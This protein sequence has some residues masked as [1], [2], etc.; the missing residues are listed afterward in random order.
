[1][2]VGATI[3]LACGAGVHQLHSPPP[4]RAFISAQLGPGDGEEEDLRERKAIDSAALAL[5]ARTET[6]KTATRSEMAEYL[7]PWAQE[8][9]LDDDVNDEYEGVQVSQRAAYLH[10]RR[11]EGR[12]WDEDDY[13]SD[14]AGMAEFTPDELSEDYALPLETVVAYMLAI[15][16]DAK[17]LNLEKPVKGMC[18]PE[19]I[20]ELTA[21]LS[22]VDPIAAREELCESTLEELADGMPLT[23]DELLNLCRQNDISALIG[24]ETR[25]KVDDLD[26]LLDAAEREIAFLGDRPRLQE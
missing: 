6:Y 2:R 14:G 1:M 26:S 25:I 12:L 16:V 11:V 13:E 17:R 18:S 19:Q 7:P 3:L 10:E 8:I 5:V 15:G 24:V 4:A 22:S 23:A 21:F 9:M 20:T